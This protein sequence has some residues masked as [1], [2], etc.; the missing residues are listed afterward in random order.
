MVAI[1]ISPEKFRDQ[2]IINPR[3]PGGIIKGDRNAEPFDAHV[4]V[5]STKNSDPMTSYFSGVS[6]AKTVSAE[7][8]DVNPCERVNFA[9]NSVFG[10]NPNFVD[11]GLSPAHT[12]DKP[13]SVI[14]STTRVGGLKNNTD[15][16]TSRHRIVEVTADRVSE[17]K[18]YSDNIKNSDFET[19]IF[20]EIRNN[21]G[22]PLNQ[23][24]RPEKYI[25]QI[26]PES[27]IIPDS[28]INLDSRINSPIRV[29]SPI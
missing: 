9:S 28:Q 5:N 14:S 20:F 7:V 18:R 4:N 1:S 21:S 3:H 16:L 26:N 27:Q 23:M 6:G 17:A 10:K 29:N 13:K 11:L 12:A 19:L 8:A 24:T 22:T 25:S 15:G 2:D